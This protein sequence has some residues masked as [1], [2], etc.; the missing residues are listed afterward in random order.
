MGGSAVKIN[1]LSKTQTYWLCQVSG[2]FSIVVIETINYTFVLT[3]TF[4]W[5]YVTGF[6][7]QAIYGILVSH[8][9][10]VIFIKKNTFDKPF[11]KLWFKGIVDT[12]SISL[13]IT[14]LLIG[15]TLIQQ[16]E[17][18]ENQLSA[19]L[20]DLSG[21]ILNHSRYVVVWIIIYYMYQILQRNRKITHEKLQMEKILTSTELELLKN[22]LNP[23]FLFNALN[24]IK[25]L[26]L[27]NSQLAQDAIT[28]LTELLQF[29]LNHE[30]ATFINIKEEI[31]QVE[32][33]LELEKIR[34][35]NRLS[36][37]FTVDEKDLFHPVPP[38]L[39]LTMA[40]N[41]IK[42]GITKLPEGGKITIKINVSDKNLCIQLENSGRLQGDNSK[43]IGLK[44]IS[45]RLKHLYG[46]LAIVN[47]KN[48]DENSVLTTICYPLRHGN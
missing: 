28:K 31:Y 47:L 37:D 12:L 6:S 23:H 4:Q 3:D 26:I 8:F 35:G 46:E 24:S 7:I 10:K 45:G 13:L 30:K 48:Q 1:R 17:F 34:F 11:K 15:P 43:G 16:W 21:R 36:F 44:N 14:V 32:K 25:A 19:T 42:H 39:I 33:Y 27:I 9:Y 5:E 38:A 20:I 41:A 2:W 40:E 18:F 22:Q 29:I